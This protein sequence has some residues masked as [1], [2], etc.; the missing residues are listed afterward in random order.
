MASPFLPRSGYRRAVSPRRRAGAT[1]LAGAIVALLLFAFLHLGGIAPRLPGGR[2]LS[3]F[4]VLPEGEKQEAARPRREEKQAAQKSPPAQV[5]PP[6]PPPPPVPFKPPPGMILL[7]RDEMAG[8][9]I[10]KMERAAK[11]TAVAG[12]GDD[13]PSTAGGPGGERLYEAEWYRE[14]P[15]NVLALYLPGGA[16]A[17]SWATIA[18]RTID[19][20]HVDSCVQLDDS[21]RGLGLSRALR[22]AAWQFLVRPPRLGGKPLIGAWV[23]IRFTFEKPPPG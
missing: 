3:T 9:D 21:P 13:T 10:G 17:G 7:T 11:G 8:A 18:C 1:L 4:T 6:V 20:Y 5:R 23:R 12:A 15:K 16:P 22:N 2:S 19:R 14:P